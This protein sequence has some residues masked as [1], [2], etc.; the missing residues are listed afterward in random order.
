MKMEIILSLLAIC[1][2]VVLFMLRKRVDTATKNWVEKREPELKKRQEGLLKK[3]IETGVVT[4]E[5]VQEWEKQGIDAYKKSSERQSE[6]LQAKL[7]E[8]DEMFAGKKRK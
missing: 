6:Q 3:H 5:E 2:L 7:K 4:K 1:A 8:V